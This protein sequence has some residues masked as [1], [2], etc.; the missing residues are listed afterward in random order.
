MSEY[1][2]A[3]TDDSIDSIVRG[4][5]KSWLQGYRDL[6]TKKEQKAVKTVLRMYM[7]ESVVKTDEG[8]ENLEDWGHWLSDF[9]G[10][11]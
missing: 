7:I 9:Y 2:V 6:L 8:P 3:L 10:E 11:G 4:E 5:M 1:L